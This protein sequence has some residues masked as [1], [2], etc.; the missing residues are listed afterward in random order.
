ME[1]IQIA[2]ER[3]RRSLPQVFAQVEGG[4][5]CFEVTSHGRPVARIVPVDRPFVPLAEA[6]RLPF[7]QGET[8]LVCELR[9]GH[10]GDCRS[11]HE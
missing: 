2:S 6:C 4:G 9:R 8:R 7:L 5:K 1:Y 11:P 3:L 10:S